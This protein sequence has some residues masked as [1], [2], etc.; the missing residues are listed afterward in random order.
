[1]GKFFFGRLE[2]LS[3]HGAAEHGVLTD[4]FKELV[5]ALRDA[6][7]E[8]AAELLVNFV[9]CLIVAVNLKE[10]LVNL[11][12]DVCQVESQALGL[13]WVVEALEGNNERLESLFEVFELETDHALN[14]HLLKELLFSILV[15]NLEDGHLEGFW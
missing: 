5:W 11:D 9:D 4:L 15:H 2:E 7:F 12:H 6:L 13:R 1:M 8:T 3:S 14:E 10:T